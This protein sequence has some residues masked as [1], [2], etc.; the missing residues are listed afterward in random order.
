LWNKKEEEAG[1]V[2]WN[3]K[4]NPAAGQLIG[5]AGISFA[6]FSLSLVPSRQ[7]METQKHSAGLDAVL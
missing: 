5:I 4:K 7:E 2:E 1:A 6:L 3:K